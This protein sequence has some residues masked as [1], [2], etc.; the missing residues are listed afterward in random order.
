MG[1]RASVFVIGPLGVLRK[2]DVLRYADDYYE[3]APEGAVVLGTVA[4][5]VTNEQSYVLATMCD[6]RPWD[7]WNHKITA[8]CLP[9]FILYPFIGEDHI[10]DVYNKIMDLLAE[11]DVQIWYEPNG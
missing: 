2:H 11:K 8:A 7:L 4:R 10:E 5:A 1:I 6:T 3:D 9:D